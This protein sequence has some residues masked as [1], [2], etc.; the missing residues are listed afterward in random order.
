MVDRFS[1]NHKASYITTL[2][3]LQNWSVKDRL[4][5]VDMPTLVLASEFDYT[6]IEEK[7]EY[8]KLF[9]NARLKIIANTRHA[10]PV[11]APGQFN[12]LLREFLAA[13]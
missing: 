1:T 2:K 10:L 7:Q 12:V 3:S 9:P 6:P 11:E 13:L 8:V 4:E 5:A